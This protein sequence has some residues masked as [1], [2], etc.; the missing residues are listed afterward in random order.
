M[1]QLE[2]IKSK[3]D[4]VEFIQGYLPLKKAGRN[5]KASCP[6]HN[7]KTPSFMVSPERQIWHC[8]GCGEGGDVFGFLMKTEGMDFSEALKILAQKTSVKLKSQA[9]GVSDKKDR[10]FRIY[11]IASLL[12]EKILWETEAG[13]PVLEYLK[14]RQIKGFTIKEFSLG[15]APGR[16]SVLIDFLSKK[17]FSGSEILESGL[18][19][20]RRGLLVDLFR[21]RLVFPFRNLYGEVIGFTGR[22]LNDDIMPKYLN[23]P[24]TLIFDK[25]RVLYDL[26][27][28]KEEIRKKDLAILVEGQMD[29]LSSYQLG[30]QN[31]I[32]SSGTALTDAQ[33][34]FIK[35]FTKNVALAFDKDE[36]GSKAIKRSID[37]LIEKSMEVKVII[38]PCGKDPDECVREDPKSWQKA[39][40]KPI[41]VM[42]F[43]FQDIFDKINKS[44][45]DL[46]ISDK[47]EISRVLL[48]QIKKIPDKIEQAGYIQRLA[49][50]LDVE[51][52]VIAD[53]LGNLSSKKRI[54]KKEEDQVKEPSRDICAELFVGIIVRFYNEIKDTLTRIDL[55]DED[56]IDK[57]L[58][59]IYKNLQSF[60]KINKLFTLDHF[61]KSLDERLK[62]KL[63]LSLMSVDFFY[64]DINER[65]LPHEVE[66]LTKRLKGINYSNQKKLIE[67]A[68]KNA[69]IKKNKAEI[70]KLMLKLREIVDKERKML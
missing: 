62:K 56:F 43:Y 44:P 10:F 50:L 68:L 15:L 18:A 66:L 69:E 13:K 55:K 45:Q 8:F 27:L 65:E 20:K 34:D 32:C 46:T 28:A 59:L 6:F 26:S 51:D 23:T 64:E 42:D 40:K 11:K 3:I 17:G 48:P 31:V 5:Y 1:D 22:A 63:E 36:A 57:D 67:K 2:E 4:I 19:L 7:E 70:N 30:I 24:Q 52:R 25:S 47:K 58:V 21:N 14:N 61:I 54:E 37:N 41:L 9:P 16:G 60:L 49:E 12:Y 35:R 38:I 29:V 53:A 39:S 33:I